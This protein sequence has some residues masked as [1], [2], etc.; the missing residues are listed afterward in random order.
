MMKK[1]MAAAATVLAIA[2]GMAASAPALAMAGDLTLA[3]TSDVG[4]KGN[5]GSFSVALSGDATRVAFESYATTLDVGDRDAS[6]DVY[7]KNLVTGDIVLASTSDS[8]V[9]G[10]GESFAPAISSDGTKVVF[11]STATNLD[12]AD[13][14]TGLD[15]YVKNLTNGDLSLVSRSDSGTKGNGESFAPALSADGAIVA[16][17]SSATNLDPADSDSTFDVF[18][19]NVSSGN[20]T[21]AS[22]SDGGAK[23]NRASNSP[24]LSS[25]GGVVAFDSA[26]TNLDPADSDTLQDVYVKTLATGDIRLASVPASGAKSNGNSFAPALSEAGNIVSFQT[27]ATNLDALDF[28]AFQDI[29]VK[30]LGTGELTLA[31]TTDTG[32]KGNAGSVLPSLSSNGRLVAFHSSA[33]N[34]D[35]GDIDTSAD[36]YVKDLPTDDVTLASTSGGGAKGD[37]SSRAPSVS[38]DGTVVAFDSAST[39]LDPQDGDT[40]QDIYVKELGA[41]TLDADL[42]ISMTD[43][44]DP[45][46][47]GTDLTYT[48]TVSNDGPDDAVAVRVANVLASG[49]IVASLSTTQGTC[50]ESGGT[51]SC[52][53]GTMGSQAVTITIAVSPTRSGTLGDTATVTSDTTDPDPSNNLATATT[54]VTGKTCTIVGTQNKDIIDGTEGADVICGL[55]RNDTLRG[56]LGDDTV[57]GGEGKDNL[58]GQDGADAAFG[59]NGDDSIAG[60]DGVSGNDTLNGGPGIDSCTADSG[61]KILGC[62]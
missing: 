8:G 12:P 30:D 28:D 49:M 7:V 43:A 34:L 54:K 44:P 27:S 26:A 6:R 23:G 60:V 38:S 52:D 57:Y 59:G 53:V 24:T 51:V 14:G 19:K 4:L 21:L 9:K 16:F 45:V 3:S 20:L 11:H 33:T 2:S 1:R 50:A 41:P 35:P 48:L 40:L 22:R 61:D 56:D 31:S 58:N 46:Q 17:V 13:T 25:D 39:N 18:T 55:G 36:I 47:V 42:A 37:R 32:V 62:E 10:N 5:A 15:I 29:Y